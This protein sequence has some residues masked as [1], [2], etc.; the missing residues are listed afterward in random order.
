MRV[1]LVRHG[2]SEWNASRRLQGQADIGLSDIGRRQADALR[3][4]IEAIGPCRAISSDLDRVRETARR[5]GAPDARPTERL[6]EIDVGDWTGR[7]IEDIKAENLDAYLGWRA[8]TATPGGGETWEDFSARVCGVIEEERAAPC[9]KLL[10]VAHGGVIRAI[11][12]RYLRLNPENMI[13]V[14]PASLSTLRLANG[15]R[16]PSRLELFN[17]HP[18]TLEFEAPD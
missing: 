3:P 6:R 17:Y 8:G 10:V 1:L 7:S 12:Q 5:I 13:P 14:G 16:E 11:L 9:Q 2:Q 4:V 15:V 18:Q